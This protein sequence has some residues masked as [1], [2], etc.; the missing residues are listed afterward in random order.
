[1][2]ATLALATT[3]ASTPPALTAENLEARVELA[4]Q[5]AEKIDPKHQK[6]IENDIELGK[7]VSE[8]IEKEKLLSSN[9][10]MVARLQRI[11]GIVAKIANETHAKTLWG[12]K[13]FSKFD[14]KFN[15]IKGDDVNAFSL[16]GGF[17]YAH[18]GLM[19]Y[20]E[21]DDEL[22]GVMAHEIAHAAQRHVATIQRQREKQMIWEIPVMIAAILGG[23]G[24]GATGLLIGA[25][26]VGLEKYTG[27][28]RDAE[29]AADHAGFEYI[30]KTD[31]NP[32]GLLTLV[33]RLARDDRNRP[34]NIWTIFQTHPPSQKRAA[35]IA[36]WMREKR[37]PIERSAVTKSFS[38]QLKKQNDG[39]IEAWFDGKK[40]H[41]FRGE[42][43][44]ER[45]EIA[46]KRLNVFFDSTPSLI[47]VQARDN[48][49]V[50]KGKT[51]FQITLDD[52]DEPTMLA[53][54]AVKG[55]QNAVFGL[56]YSIWK[57]Y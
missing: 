36:T 46:E 33:E 26:V 34:K 48:K 16:P 30:L 17:I 20:V 42:T 13:R 18:E 19:T 31:Y 52:G 53:Q 10:A 14:Y 2:I 11:G 38:V 12:D 54:S 45:A 35:D 49:I 55:I 28:G 6:D 57:P 9:E 22:A 32:T 3:L 24:K 21:S 40:L 29:R 37:V 25:Q 7:G 15:V 43:A 8:D 4:W 23:G 5:E 44:Q 27:W 51:L 39:T 41:T 56:N 50:G 1:M 47:D